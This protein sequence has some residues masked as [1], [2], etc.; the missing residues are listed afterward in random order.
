MNAW[1]LNVLAISKQI[2]EVFNVWVVLQVVIETRAKVFQQLVDIGRPRCL[3][4]LEVEDG[5][6][7]D[8]LPRRYRR[9]LTPQHLR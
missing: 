5:L 8:P 6:T 1:L 7:Q 4:T 3:S 2:E 9:A